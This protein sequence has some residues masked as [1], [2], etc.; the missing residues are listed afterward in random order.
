MDIF[1]ACLVTIFICSW[2]VTH[3]PL[4]RRNGF[5]GSPPKFWMGLTAVLAPEGLATMAFLTY[6]ISK[7]Y[8]DT[9]RKM[10]KGLWTLS[11]TYFVV[12]GG[13]ELQFKD[14]METLGRQPGG[15]FNENKALRDLQRALQLDLLAMDAMSA[16]DV[17]SRAKTNHFV[18]TLVCLQ[19]SWLLAQVIGR[20]ATKLPIT[21]LEIV[22]VGYVVCAVITYACWWHKPQDAEV[23]ITVDCRNLTKEE[24]FQQLDSTVNIPK[25]FERW[26][27]VLLFITVGA[28]GA[29]HCTAW[30]F[31]FA[32]FT[33]SVIWRVA[34]V[35]TVLLPIMFVR[36]VSFSMYAD[37]PSSPLPKFGDWVVF[38]ATVLL[39]L[40]VRLYLIAEPFVAFRSVPVG[41][42]YMVDWSSWLPHI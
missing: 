19:A 40:P 12:M 23:F 37:F 15:G 36:F 13:V 42:F 33:E 6:R 17:R 5:W 3:P 31:M 10:D 22:T 34:S 18:K 32:T 39:Y 14:C 1:W 8:T 16:E 25:V 11:Q 28:F 29:V 27:E 7:H 24:F 35:L 38:P 20:A 41:V 2:T 9:I 26:E 4:P 30:N 21:T